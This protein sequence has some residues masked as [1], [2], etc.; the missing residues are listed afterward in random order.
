MPFPESSLNDEAGKLF[1]E[2]YEEYFWMAKLMTQI[3]A[4]WK[5][6]A[7]PT[8]QAVFGDAPIRKEKPVS[9]FSQPPEPKDVEMS[10]QNQD[11]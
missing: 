2:D 6:V 3:H 10:N 4:L 11:P 1:M 5:K 8:P 9:I 7:K